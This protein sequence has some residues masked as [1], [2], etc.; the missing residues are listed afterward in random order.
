MFLLTMLTSI[1]FSPSYRNQRLTEKNY[2]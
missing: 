2:F 1:I